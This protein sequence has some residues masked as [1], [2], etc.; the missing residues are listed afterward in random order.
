MSNLKPAKTLVKKS[1]SGLGL[2]AVEP[3]KKKQFIIRYK[4]KLLNNKQAEK[5]G[6]KYLFEVNSRWTI[7]GTPRSNKARYINH[8][9]RESNAEPIVYGK[10]VRIYARKNIKPGE[11]IHYN[12]GRIYFNDYIK[13]YGCRCEY[14]LTKRKTPLKAVKMLK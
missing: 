11:E 10:E 8:A 3:I 12:Y 7:D 4:G 5:K 2:F 1:H 6:G 9:C 13:P 14:C